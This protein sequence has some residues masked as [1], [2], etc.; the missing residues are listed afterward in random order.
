MGALA[1]V[2]EEGFGPAAF[3]SY[4]STLANDGITGDYGSGFYGYAV[5][6]GTYITVHPHFG[7]V[8]FSGNIEKKGD[9]LN[10]EVTSAGK[11][12][13]FIAPKKLWVTL[14]AGK[15]DNVNYNTKT[16]EV[17]LVLAPADEFTKTAYIN[18]QTPGKYEMK[19]DRDERGNYKV[20]LSSQPQT[21]SIKLD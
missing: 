17:Q 14:D 8:A 15:V 9:W 5:N 4:P 18:V 10:T 21:L 13:V 7:P 6:S 16:G 2:T 12:R 19:A 20:A 11:S 1:N 3:H